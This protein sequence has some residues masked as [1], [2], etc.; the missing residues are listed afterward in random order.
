MN[1]NR[2]CSIDG[3]ENQYFAKNL[4]Q[5]H[6]RRFERHG[7]PLKCKIFIKNKGEKC[8]VDF[9]NKD[10][11]TKGLCFKHYYHFIRYDNPLGGKEIELHGMCGTPEYQVWWNMIDR[12]TN[13]DYSAYDYYGG[14]GIT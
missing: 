8:K 13:P 1:K 2:M 4:C 14:R 7:D 6:Y 10:A 5:K 9:C 11:I 3:C 12:C